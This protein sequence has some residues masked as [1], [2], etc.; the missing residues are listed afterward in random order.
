MLALVIAISPAFAWQREGIGVGSV[1][2][3]LVQVGNA[4]D[5]AGS[6]LGKKVS[7]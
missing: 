5:G 4:A 7:I 2:T 3:E 1:V 6:G